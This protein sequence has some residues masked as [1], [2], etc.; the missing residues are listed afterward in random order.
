MTRRLEISAIVLSTLLQGGAY[1]LWG[2]PSALILVFLV[3]VIWLLTALR[4]RLKAG[5]VCFVLSSLLSMLAA[6]RS[7][8]ALVLIISITALAAW[9]LSRFNAQ[10]REIDPAEAAARIEKLHLKRLGYTLAAG[11]GAGLLA[12]YLRVHLSFTMAVVL[13]FAGLLVTSFVISRLFISDSKP[14]EV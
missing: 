1:L 14:P 4:G 13:G 6:L 7:P 10:L 2:Q 3:G 5:T 12:I 9:D 8:G 11:L